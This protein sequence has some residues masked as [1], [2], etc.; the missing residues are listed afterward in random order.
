M[1]SKKNTAIIA[2]V[3][4][5]V[6][7][8]ALFTFLRESGDDGA[9][10]MFIDSTVE[11]G[12]SY[13]F[14]TAQYTDGQLKGTSAITVT[15]L[16]VT[17]GSIVY[18]YSDGSITDT[19]TESRET[20]LSALIVQDTELLGDYQRTESIDTLDGSR[21][22]M[23][24]LV[25]VDLDDDTLCHVYSWIPVGSNVIVRSETVVSDGSGTSFISTTLSDTNMLS[26]TRPDDAVVPEAAALDDT[27]RENVVA[28][29]Y[30]EFSVYSEGYRDILSYSVS[31]VT[32][33]TLWIYQDGMNQIPVESY[34]SLVRYDGNG[35]ELDHE[36][37]DSS[38]GPKDCTIY[39][40]DSYEGIFDIGSAGT[41]LFW[42]DSETG[43]VYMI[44]L[45]SDSAEPVFY[46]LTG[47]SLLGPEPDPPTDENGR[48]VVSSSGF[49]ITVGDVVE[50]DMTFS[51]GFSF[52][53]TMTVFNVTND[54]V[55]VLY[56]SGSI[57]NMG[58]EE[59]ADQFSLTQS[60]IDHME[61]VEYAWTSNGE[62]C[63]VYSY[64]GSQYYTI[65]NGTYYLIAETYVPD[66]HGQ[67]HT[68]YTYSV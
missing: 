42:A 39:M 10:G 63:S 58:I 41:V 31:A 27:I 20:F 3:A 17:D 45:I 60:R 8:A 32:G 64:G 36:T 43:V 65:Y 59:Y 15:V 51:Y 55:V 57:R 68:V 62:L 29:D 6:L 5:V 52:S 21:E 14:D 35:T 33:D 46:Y 47:T 37:I 53:S 48:T 28:G 11:V 1:P 25:W 13:T 30:V 40:Y 50:V 26:E 2:V 67:T 4:V 49:A 56:S 16:E 44:G 18:S 61:F 19:V 54:T 66:A 7:L 34:L 23:V 38:F 24:Y 12:D 22:C 9:D